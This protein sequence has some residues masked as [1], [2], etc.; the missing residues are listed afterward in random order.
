M[1]VTPLSVDSQ[2]G[3]QRKV[4]ILGAGGHAKVLL[5]ALRAQGIN[6]DGIVDPELAETE[7]VW[8][9]LPVLGDD[10][11]LL[12]LNPTGFEVVNGVGSLPGS[13]L[14]KKLFQQF[15]SVGFNFRSVIHP[16]AIIGSGVKLGEGAQ[17]MAGS[18]IQP[19]CQVGEN[20]IVNTGAKLDHDCS[21]G[22]NVHIAPGVT[23][24]GNVVIEDGVHIGT[25]ASVVHGVTIGRETVI[26]AGTV[27]VK[28]VPEHSKLIGAKPRLHSISSGSKQ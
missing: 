24:S 9:E 8:R 26:G 15:K 10:E 18:V 25:G 23:I 12:E 7:K 21:V 2:N 6:V 3:D 19:D 4:V 20:T 16:S 14:R 11:K 1:V 13:N 28:S 5:D 17:V 22:A 27:V